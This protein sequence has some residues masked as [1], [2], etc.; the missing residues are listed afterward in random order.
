MPLEPF[1]LAS[2]ITL[3][4]VAGAVTE[5]AL[6]PYPKAEDGFIRQVI[7]LPKKDN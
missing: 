7:D 4:L 5:K 3:P 6:K 2:L 1:V